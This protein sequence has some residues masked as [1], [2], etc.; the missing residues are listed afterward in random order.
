MKKLFI[1]FSLALLL[2]AGSVTSSAKS[3]YGVIGGMTFNSAKD[4]SRA[5]MTQW[6]AGFTYKLDL[7]A[8]F[9]FQPSLLY[10]TRGTKT[11]TEYESG[12]LDFR[13]SY[14]ELPL[15]IQW[16]PDLLLF[17]PFLEV[18]PY[19]GYALDNKILTTGGRLPWDDMNRFEYGLGLGV[20][21][22]LW[23]LQIIGRYCWNFGSLA[24]SNSTGFFK[25]AF[26]DN[27]FRGFMLSL[28][29]LFGGR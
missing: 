29:I 2:V 19:I 27:N 22:E 4:I 10:Q 21:L 13:A 7:P 14:L 15:S 23:R 5:N 12:K 3:R 9:A 20:G 6:H 24:S 26:R 17:R 25:D 16:G 11:N 28:S 1:L 8:G 18:T